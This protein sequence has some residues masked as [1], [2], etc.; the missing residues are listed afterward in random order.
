MAKKQGENENQ[1][2]YNELKEK[3][4]SAMQGFDEI[5]LAIE[6]AKK[7]FV[8]KNIETI[9]AEVQDKGNIKRA[10]T[11]SAIAAIMTAAVGF[12]VNVES[13]YFAQ[14]T[15]NALHEIGV[16]NAADFAIPYQKIFLLFLASIPISIIGGY[17]YDYA[18]YRLAK[19]IGGK[20][21]F[22]KQYY[23]SSILGI[24]AFFASL[25]LIISP[26]PGIGFVGAV[27]YLIANIYISIYARTIAY[28]KLHQI[29]K[30]HAF[31]IVIILSIITFLLGMYI[32][33]QFQNYLEIKV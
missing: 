20:S 32:S 22:E 2:K 25:I 23:I 12:L 7:M 19:L 15:L 16:S 24:S 27:V 9:V 3:F 11:L 18:A 5:E 21:T 10:I 31:L 1:K 26:V 17:I 8:P 6:S 13:I 4:R 28:S 14:F 33:N 29:S 30:I